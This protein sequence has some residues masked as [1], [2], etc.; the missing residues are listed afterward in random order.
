[1]S[2]ADRIHVYVGEPLRRLL[3]TRG[4]R[5]EGASHVV[6]AVAARYL[7][8]TAAS[9]PALTEAEWMATADTLNGTWLDEG[10]IRYVAAEIAD[11]DRLNGLGAKWGID[12]QALARHLGAAP[13]AVRLA[14][15]EIVERL[16][17][18]PSADWPALLASWGVL[19]TTPRTGESTAPLSDEQVETLVELVRAGRRSDYDALCGALGVTNGPPLWDGLTRRLRGRLEEE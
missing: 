5:G 18:Q 16:W 19:P 2:P 4:N 17:A 1:M 13:Y 11:A 8:V 10:T 15:V 3:D 12:A 9:L 14:V 6:N 7:A